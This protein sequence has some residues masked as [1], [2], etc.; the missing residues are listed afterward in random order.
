MPSARTVLSDSSRQSGE[1]ETAQRTRQLLFRQKQVARNEAR[2]MISQRR[3]ALDES[4]MRNETKA[5]EYAK[6]FSSNKDRYVM[7]KSYGL[8]TCCV[9]QFPLLETVASGGFGIS[10]NMI[11]V[12][13]SGF[14]YVS[15][16]TYASRTNGDCVLTLALPDMDV[17]LGRLN[18]VGHQNG[19]RVIWLD[20]GTDITVSAHDNLRSTSVDGLDILIIHMG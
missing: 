14:Y 3:R 2:A 7:A 9:N 20:A 10:G 12:P 13:D 11:R 8:D 16:E 6:Q 15:W 1:A 17:E 4:R 18:T 5:I 19:S